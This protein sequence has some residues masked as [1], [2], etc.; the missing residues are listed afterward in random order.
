MKTKQAKSPPEVEQRSSGWELEHRYGSRVHILDNLFLL[1]A[2]ARL[3]GKHVR[4]PEMTATLRGIYQIML[5]TVAGH[6]LPRVQSEIPTRMADQHP[7]EGVYRGAVVD[8]ATRI[9]IVD[10]IRAGIV[11]SQACFEMLTSVLP[12][13]NVRLDHL[14][15]A[16]ISD[17]QGHVIGVDLSGSKIGGTVDGSMLLLPDPM[18]ATGSTT[19]RAVKHYLEHHG[20]PTRII[21]MPMMATPEYLR[22]VTSAFENLVVYTARLDRGMS[23][24]DVLEC[25]P[26]SRWTE[27]R[28]LNAK[29]Y[30]VP[31]AGGM[32]EVLNNSWC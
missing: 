10:I 5:A 31:G 30:I 14:N 21:A 9:V 25:V 24:A 22:A 6:E 23:P 3:G 11:P 7:R 1:T 8:P 18:G 12:D 2:L 26:G 16:R 4:H 20:Q 28:G 27:E 32:G 13:D 15:M 19:I 17:E 29:G